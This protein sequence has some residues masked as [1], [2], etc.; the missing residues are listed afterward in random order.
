MPPG[1]LLLVRFGLP[2]FPQR[3]FDQEDMEIIV[4][5]FESRLTHRVPIFPGK[6]EHRFDS[7]TLKWFL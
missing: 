3:V 2:S 7:C 6:M 1:F 5:T 4:T